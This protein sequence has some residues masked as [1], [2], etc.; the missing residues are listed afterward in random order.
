MS[1]IGKSM[2]A[3]VGTR[4]TAPGVHKVT[5]IGGDTAP[6]GQVTVPLVLG[7]GDSARQLSV[8]ALVVESIS[9]VDMLLSKSVIKSLGETRV[10]WEHNRCYPVLP[11]S[12]SG[13]DGVG[14]DGGGVSCGSSANGASCSDSSN[15]TRYAAAGCRWC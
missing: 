15:T 11:A 1:V 14:L 9:G 6:L 13:G 3:T 8:V 2:A 4:W 5:G 7:T 12:D 10:D